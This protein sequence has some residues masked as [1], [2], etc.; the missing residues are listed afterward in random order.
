MTTS[1]KKTKAVKKGRKDS[2]KK[3]AS[4]KVRA[5]ARELSLK[6]TPQGPSPELFNT[7]S[8]ELLQHTSCSHSLPR[9][10]TNCSLSSW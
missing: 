1:R 10:E 2:T 9:R 8:R 7:V 5:V 6:I 3:S 4:K